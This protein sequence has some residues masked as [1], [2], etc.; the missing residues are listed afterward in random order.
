ML[1]YWYRALRSEAGICLRSADRAHT[2]QQLYKSRQEAMDPDLKHLSI[3][4]SPTD[5]AELWIIKK[6][7]TDD[8][9]EAP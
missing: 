2:I 3:V 8:S 5:P 6:A 7:P 9:S 4:Q 1:E